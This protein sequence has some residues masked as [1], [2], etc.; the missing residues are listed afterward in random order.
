MT[1]TSHPDIWTPSQ[2]LAGSETKTHAVQTESDGTNAIG[3]REQR[4]VWIQPHELE[5]NPNILRGDEP[6]SR[7]KKG[8]DRARWREERGPGRRRAGTE[9]RRRAQPWRETFRKLL[10][11]VTARR[12]GE[13]STGS[14]KLPSG[15]DGELFFLGSPS[16]I[17]TG[18]F[19]L[20]V[21]F[22]LCHVGL[23]K[24]LI[25]RWAVAWCAKGALVACPR[26]LGCERGGMLLVWV[27]CHDVSS[28]V[29]SLSFW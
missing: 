10:E 4:I 17:T 11:A 6:P 14:G 16:L 24:P 19:L 29:V 22:F 25:V 18:E 7:E 12:R 26:R 9:W 27:T 23:S 5:L 28:T 1:C 8:S 21:Y 20:F 13:S 3:A 2:I 15:G